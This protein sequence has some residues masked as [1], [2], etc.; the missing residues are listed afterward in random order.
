MKLRVP[1]LKVFELDSMAGLR[2]PT[3]RRREK[4]EDDTVRR[5]SSSGDIEEP[6]RWARRLRHARSA[7]HARLSLS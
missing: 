4:R 5:S 7:A 3:A 6:L 2:R 1:E